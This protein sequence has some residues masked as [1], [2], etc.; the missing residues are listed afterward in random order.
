M[1]ISAN[2]FIDILDD[3]EDLDF[4]GTIETGV[5]SGYK[6]KMKPSC[7]HGNDFHWVDYT[8]TFISPKKIKT[9]V[10]GRCSLASGWDFNKTIII[11]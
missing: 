4:N 3:L 9:V 8:L 1:R 5:L 10:E 11:K 2:D 6:L 7:E